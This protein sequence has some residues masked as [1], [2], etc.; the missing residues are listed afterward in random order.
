M[1]P[2]TEFMLKIAKTILVPYIFSNFFIKSLLF[3]VDI[4]SP[5]F[6]MES[7]SFPWVIQV[8]AE[9]VPKSRFLNLVSP[10]FQGVFS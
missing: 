3:E 4:I 10:N 1:V 7:P 9:V 8:L 5:C 2:K 6:N